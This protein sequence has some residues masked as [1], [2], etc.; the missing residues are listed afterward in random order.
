MAGA[1]SYLMLAFYLEAGVKQD[2]QEHPEK[3]T[4][5]FVEGIKKYFAQFYRAEK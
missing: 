2:I 4:S 3:Y 1:Y 5:P